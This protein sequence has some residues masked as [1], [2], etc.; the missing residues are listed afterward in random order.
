MYAAYLEE[1]VVLCYQVA[2]QG[3]QPAAQHHASQQ[4]D[5]G[6]DAAEV[7]QGQVKA[8]HQGDIDQLRRACEV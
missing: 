8:H 4:E 7:E 1:H 6:L 5:E 3:M 2:S